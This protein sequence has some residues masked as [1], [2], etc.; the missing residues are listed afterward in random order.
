MRE[1][2]TQNDILATG[3]VDQHT[4]T[5][6]NAEVDRQEPSFVVHGQVKRA[7]GIPCSRAVVRAWDR[8]LRRQQLLGDSVTSNNGGYRITYSA[9]Q[10]A[11]AEK[12]AA[13]LNRTPLSWA[14]RSRLRSETNSC[15]GSFRARS[16]T[17]SI[18]SEIY[19]IRAEHCGMSHV[20]TSDVW[21]VG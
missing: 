8:D 12:D 6:V 20:D 9:E 13:D 15:Q 7:D 3:T 19:G 1:F 11:L 4:A 2:Q 18:A 14:M 21:W 16:T 17:S 10:G 5:R